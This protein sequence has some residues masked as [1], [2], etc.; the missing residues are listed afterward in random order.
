MIRKWQMVEG[1]CLSEIIDIPAGKRSCPPV[2]PLGSKGDDGVDG[3]ARFEACPSDVSFYVRRRKVKTILGFTW[4][5]SIRK[6]EEQ[7]GRDCIYAVF[8]TVKGQDGRK[9]V[10]SL[11]L[12]VM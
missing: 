12:I 10:T 7:A 3:R 6:L 5:F 9:A 1:K 11:L 2:C 4:L 8:G